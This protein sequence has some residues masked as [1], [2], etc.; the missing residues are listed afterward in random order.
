VVGGRCVSAVVV[1]RPFQS[2]AAGMKVGKWEN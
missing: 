1:Q 2:L